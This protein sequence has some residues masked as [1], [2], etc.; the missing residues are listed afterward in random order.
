LQTVEKF[1]VK[2]FVAH[3]TLLKYFSASVTPKKFGWARFEHFFG[4]AFVASLHIPDLWPVKVLP[5]E[6]PIWGLT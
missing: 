5:Q 6:F 4:L 3:S 1:K 2:I